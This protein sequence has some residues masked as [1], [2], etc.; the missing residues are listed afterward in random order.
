MGDT[1]SKFDELQD[2]E[3]RA[4]GKFHPKD[5]TFVSI[6]YGFGWKPKGRLKI[7][8]DKGNRELIKMATQRC[9]TPYQFDAIKRIDRLYE[10]GQFEKD[11]KETELILRL[12]QNNK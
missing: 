12:M 11:I 6:P 7:P 4:K 1:K 10:N 2:S 8:I 5:Q 3:K 9:W